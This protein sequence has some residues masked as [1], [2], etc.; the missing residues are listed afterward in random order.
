MSNMTNGDVN[1]TSASV[2]DQPK[3]V[4]AKEG[5]VQNPTV[6]N[7]VQ[8]KNFYEPLETVTKYKFTTDDVRDFL[9]KRMSGLVAGLKNIGE[10]A[11]DLKINLISVPNYGKLAPFMII[12]PEDAIAKPAKKNKGETMTVFTGSENE[13]CGQL[14]KAAYG[15]IAPYMYTKED[16]KSFMDSSNFHRILDITRKQGAQIASKC[17]PSP[18]NVGGTRVVVCYLDPIRIFSDM[19]MTKDDVDRARNY[20]KRGGNTTFKNYQVR[21]KFKKIGSDNCTYEVL[22]EPKKKKNT[23][24]LNAQIL[25]A[26]QANVR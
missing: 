6:R 9:Q 10:N 12:L 14:T 4:P 8:F 24:G 26:I 16:K 11:E 21:V 19:V 5:R 23:D 3:V 2:K 13:K 22:K 25:R 7:D 15:T 17:S 18:L 20:Q 1:D